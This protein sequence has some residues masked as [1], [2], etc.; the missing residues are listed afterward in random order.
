MSDKKDSEA[1]VACP[2]CHTDKQILDDTEETGVFNYVECVCGFICSVDLW[3]KVAA[4]MEKTTK[5]RA[6]LKEFNAYDDDALVYASP[7]QLIKLIRD[8]V[9]TVGETP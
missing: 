8:I 4:G 3:N 7:S 6:H 9:A 5:V 1:L 2:F